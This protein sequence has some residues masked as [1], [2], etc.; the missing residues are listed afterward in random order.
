MKKRSLGSWVFVLCAVALILSLPASAEEVE[1]KIR[2]SLSAGQF[3]TRDVVSSDSAN[4]LTIVDQN[5]QFVNYIEDPRN[6]N[7]ALGDLEIRTAPRV[8][9]TIQYAVNRFFVVEGSAGYQSG[10]VGAIE[11]QA[12]FLGTV[13]APIER[14]KYTVFEVQAGKMTQIPLQVTAIARFRPKARLN[15]YLGLGAGYTMVGFEPSSGLDTLSRRMDGLVGG[16]TRLSPYPATQ[17]QAPAASDLV[18]LSGGK[19]VADNSFEWHAVGGMEYSLKRKWAI[20]ADLR[21]VTSSRA[22]TIG[23][24]GSSGLG[25]SLP[26]RQAQQGSPIA[27]AV[28]GPVLIP[29]GG[30]VDG[31]RKINPDVFQGA[32]APPG[33]CSISDPRQCVFLRNID[34][35]AYNAKWKDYVGSDGTRFVPVSADGILDPGFY[36]VKGGSIRYSGTSLQIGVRYTF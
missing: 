16:Q 22:F 21:Y 3:N 2:V 31:G 6:D 29:N 18:A 7:A 35:Q 27:T 33:I 32:A 17:P 36:Y 20:Y 34:M 13:I 15:P 30:L 8:M 10:N 24:N 14:H 5:E 19:V 23:F 25:I 26:N 1:K 12:E 9:A 11:M 4:I 28:Y